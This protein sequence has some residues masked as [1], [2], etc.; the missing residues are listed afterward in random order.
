MSETITALRADAVDHNDVNREIEK[1]WP[2]LVDS[3]EV[4][5]EAAKAGMD[6]SKFPRGK[7]P[8]VAIRPEGQFLVAET[9]L[10]AAATGAT[11]EAGKVTLHALWDNLIWPRL[12]RRFGEQ[13]EPVS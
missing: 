10:I 6:A 5:R 13:L 1:L 8:F 12:R 11:T 7:V 3:G 9:L 4:Q 2:Q